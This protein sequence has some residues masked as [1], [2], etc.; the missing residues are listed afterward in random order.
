M[1]KNS[2]NENWS[3]WQPLMTALTGSYE[4]IK[5]GDNAERLKI[6]L[7]SVNSERKLEISIDYAWG[8]RITNESFRLKLIDQLSQK[9]GDDFYVGWPIFKVENSTY[10]KWIEDEAFGTISESRM[11][12]FVLIG[13][14]SIVDIATAAEPKIKI[15]SS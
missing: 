5:V 2:F 4:I 6:V 8:Y 1:V 7:L 14:E 13:T 10:L 12:H 11:F 9:Y 3:R 15:L